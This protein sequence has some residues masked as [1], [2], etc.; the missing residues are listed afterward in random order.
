MLD[1]T[2]IIEQ[3]HAVCRERDAAEREVAHCKELLKTFRSS[4]EEAKSAMREAQAVDSVKQSALETT[5]KMEAL[6]IKVAQLPGVH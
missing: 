1:K 5:M 3:H 4:A 6:Y 2:A